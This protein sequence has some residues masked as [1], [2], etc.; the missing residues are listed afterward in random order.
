[1]FR[2][3]EYG[4]S[5]NHP[6]YLH[7]SCECLIQGFTQTQI[8]LH[9]KDAQTLCIICKYTPVNKSTHSRFLKE[10]KHKIDRLINTRQSA[11]CVLYKQTCALYETADMI[12]ATV[13]F[14][15]YVQASLQTWM[16]LTKKIAQIPRHTKRNSINLTGPISACALS[17][18]W[19]LSTDLQR[20]LHCYN[21]P[22]AIF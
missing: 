8:N 13:A 20:T 16:Q 1:M 21:V 10:H 7:A 11:H 9:T 15:R 4:E 12:N 18:F 17:F 5:E 14:I 19:L 6:A 22:N 2:N 3:N